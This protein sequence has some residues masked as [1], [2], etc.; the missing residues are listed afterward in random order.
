MS[1]Q[2]QTGHLRQ[3]APSAAPVDSGR[4][5]T[6]SSASPA[7]STPLLSAAE[8]SSLAGLRASSFWT[9]EGM[10]T[11]FDWYTNPHNYERLRKKNP[12]AGQKQSDLHKEICRIVNNKHNTS[13]T[14]EQVK[15]KMAYVKRKYRDA[16][17]LNSSGEGPVL[18]KQEAI[19]P[20]FLRLHTVLGGNLSAN[21]PPPRQSGSKGEDLATSDDSEEESSNLETFDN[22]SDTDTNTDGR[23]V[24]EHPSKR[25]KTRGLASLDLQRSVDK[26]QQLAN[27]NKAALRAREQVVESRER[28]LSEKLLRI[29]DEASKRAEEAR[30]Q[31]RQ[32]LAAERAEL[33]Q[34]RAAE[35]A[36]FKKEM[37]FERAEIRE[38]RAALRQ[39]IEDFKRDKAQFMKERDQLLSENSAL[40]TELSCRVAIVNRHSHSR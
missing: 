1:R 19:C 37:T 31:L 25:Q 39:D 14:P 26:M 16:V 40:K 30:A 23:Y 7:S 4:P 35:R 20:L 36:E 12:V 2:Q 17:E 22:Q 24:A 13:W 6:R 11:F 9:Q 10:D 38:E 8:S 29:S 3:I 21:P 5:S 34:E 32:E 28:E 33:R 15:A 27:E 18:Q